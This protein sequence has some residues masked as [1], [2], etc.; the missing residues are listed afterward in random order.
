MVNP[1][2]LCLPRTPYP[3]IL[4][5][6]RC[7]HLTDAGFTLLARV[8]QVLP[9]QPASLPPPPRATRSVQKM[10]FSNDRPQVEQS[11]GGARGVFYTFSLGPGSWG[12]LHQ[13]WGPGPQS[14]FVRRGHSSS[15]LLPVGEPFLTDADSRLSSIPRLC[16]ALP[17]A[18]STLPCR[19]EP[20]SSWGCCDSA[21]CRIPHQ[22]PGG[23]R[24]TLCPPR[25]PSWLK[26]T[27]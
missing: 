1:L 12:V 15:S 19:P 20:L 6:A 26:S 2:L 4:E 22:P 14:H 16:R 8:R 9:N 24:P 7:S 21:S 5:A 3:R 17:L 18:P 27:C 13:E 11:P 10:A 25:D 23:E